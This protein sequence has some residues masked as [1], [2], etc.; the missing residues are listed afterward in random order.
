MNNDEIVI[1]ALNEMK[2]L[3]DNGASESQIQARE[4]QMLQDVANNQQD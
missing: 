2:T 1:N 4:A 3:S